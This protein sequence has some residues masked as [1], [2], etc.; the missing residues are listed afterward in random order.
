MKVFFKVVTGLTTFDYLCCMKLCHCWADAG[1]TGFFG[2][3]GRL[4]VEKRRH[5]VVGWLVS[6]LASG[7]RETE[8]ESG[9]KKKMWRTLVG[10]GP[11]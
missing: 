6:Q 8:G 9:R 1:T 11:G 3:R 4:G 5:C 10:R 7:A 2:R